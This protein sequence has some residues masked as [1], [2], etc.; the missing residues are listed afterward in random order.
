MQD[1]IEDSDIQDAVD[2][3]LL[4]RWITDYNGLVGNVE[5][6]SAQISHLYVKDYKAEIP[7]SLCKIQQVVSRQKQ[8]K[9]C[10]RVESVSSWITKVAP[11]CDDHQSCKKCSTVPP[12]DCKEPHIISTLQCTSC[13]NKDYCGCEVPTYEL[14]IDRR[15]EMA[16]PQHYL[17]GWHR[18]GSVGKGPGLA[19]V[20]K[21]EWM[22]LRPALD[23]FYRH[24]YFLNDC[25]NFNPGVDCKHSFKFEPP[26]ITVDFPEGEIIVAHLGKVLD[27][28]GDVMIPD[29]AHYLEGLIA[30]LDYKWWA[31]E[32]KRHAYSSKTNMRLF[33]QYSQ[34]AK[35]E[36]ELSISRYKAR[37]VVPD[38]KEWTN[39]MEKVMNQ[40][41]PNRKFDQGLKRGQNTE[42]FQ[43]YSNLLDCGRRMQ[44]YSDCG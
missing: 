8:E 29:D 4:V 9:S 43:R 34:S 25:L 5:D 36:R 44:N 33:K 16:N 12:C 17:K 27:E 22:L 42:I 14:P 19:S 3:S 24:K 23:D 41:I 31:R 26:Y 6:L 10:S 7:D 20:R 11:D 35:Q 37:I 18:A 13:K 38:Y 30:H 15:W 21:D 40:R 1:Y 32:A 2:E 39:F 28:E